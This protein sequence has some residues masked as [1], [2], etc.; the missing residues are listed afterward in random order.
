MEIG[1]VGVEV[2]V[3][4]VMDPRVETGM[5]FEVDV[6]VAEMDLGAG[7]GQEVVLEVLMGREVGWVD[8]ATSVCWKK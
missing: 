8:S 5:E 4:V 1:V 6:G 3:G 7:I 2:E